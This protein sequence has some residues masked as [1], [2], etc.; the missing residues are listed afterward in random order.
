ML[1]KNERTVVFYDLKL[2]LPHRAG[3]QVDLK[4]LLQKFKDRAKTGTASMGLEGRPDVRISL[5]D[6]EFFDDFAVMLFRVS[7][8]SV[9]NPAFEN[10]DTG[11]LRVVEKEP[12]EGVGIA[13]HLVVRL[14]P[15]AKISSLRSGYRTVLEHVDSV[16]KTKIEDLLNNLATSFPV[17][18]D[19]NGESDSKAVR[20]QLFAHTSKKLKAAL[21]ADGAIDEVVLVENK[22]ISGGIDVPEGVKP[23]ERKLRFKVAAGTS[24]DKVVGTRER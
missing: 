15:K 2:V 6:V 7:D 12:P 16:G 5:R 9:G 1:K 18:Y 11:D 24:I 14:A 21:A 10:Q 3:D 4:V 23:I 8:K 22:P 19:V 20:F 13:A 17:T